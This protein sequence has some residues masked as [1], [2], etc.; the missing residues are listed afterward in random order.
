MLDFRI[1]LIHCDISLFDSECILDFMDFSPYVP[2]ARHV[3]VMYEINVIE[4]D[5][6]V[7]ENIN[8]K[9]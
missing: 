9:C 7:R 3:N 5:A 6:Y 1:I 2:A 8:M 4:D